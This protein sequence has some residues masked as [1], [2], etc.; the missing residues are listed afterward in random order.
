MFK[1]LTRTPVAKVSDFEL[2]RPAVVEARPIN[3]L[4]MAGTMTLD[5]LQ[6]PQRPRVVALFDPLLFDSPSI[7]NALELM[8]IKGPGTP[9]FWQKTFSSISQCPS[10]VAGFL[11]ANSPRTEREWIWASFRRITAVAGE[12]AN[13]HTKHIDCRLLDFCENA[14]DITT[15]VNI[16]TGPSTI[17]HQL[18]KPVDALGLAALEPHLENVSGDRKAYAR[19]EDEFWRGRID[20]AQAKTYAP[21]AAVLINGAV[22]H[23]TPVVSPEMHGTSRALLKFHIGTME[24]GIKALQRNAAL[25]SYLGLK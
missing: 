23:E 5:M 1:F 8:P 14:G 12:R 24:P 18:A 17:Y 11:A 21:G 13:S 20:P 19:I 6:R 3:D 4:D 25:A 22:V 16:T 10:V 9:I 2:L 7:P 15:Q